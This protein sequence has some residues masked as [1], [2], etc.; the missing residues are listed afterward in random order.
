[1][2]SVLL[3][4]IVLAPDVQAAPV[5]VPLS[6]GLE[7]KTQ[8]VADPATADLVVQSRA[9]SARYGMRCVS[10]DAYGPRSPIVAGA[11]CEVRDAA[12]AVYEVRVTNVGNVAVSFDVRQT[13]TLAEGQRP[14]PFQA[15]PPD[16]EPGVLA[17]YRIAT[18]AI[19]GNRVESHF[20]SLVLHA[21]GGYQFGER[22]GRWSL[23]QGLLL[24]DGEYTAWGAGALSEDARRLTFASRGAQFSI[25]AGLEWVDPKTALM[26]QASR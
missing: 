18:Y 5:L 8:S 10:G 14:S 22:R 20:A 26:G 21:D 4:V 9:L 6:R 1:M 19:D 13:G 3:A 16:L 7:L 23:I 12:G 2:R 24:L 25:S 15:L 17:R 11:T